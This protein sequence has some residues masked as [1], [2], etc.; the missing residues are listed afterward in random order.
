MLHVYDPD[1]AGHGIGAP[2]RPGGSPTLQAGSWSA[3]IV[4]ELK[5]DP[6]DIRIEKYRMSGFF[7]SPLDSILRNLAVTTLLF[8]GVNVDQCV[9]ATLSD[10]VFHTSRDQGNLGFHELRYTG[11][12]VQGNGCP[13]PAKPTRRPATGR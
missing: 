4:D 6:D 2:V 9:L 8:A 10:V 1:G 11:R 5:P 12:G 3:E 7:D 13:H